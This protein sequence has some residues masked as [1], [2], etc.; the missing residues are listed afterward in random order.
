VI[1]KREV[2][3]IFPV[4]PAYLGCSV[5]VAVVVSA[6]GRALQASQA[7]NA[8]ATRRRQ[9]GLVSSNPP[10]LADRLATLP[11]FEY[12]L[13][14]DYQVLIERLARVGARCG[15]TVSV[16]YAQ[17]WRGNFQRVTSCGIRWVPPLPTSCE[18]AVPQTFDRSGPLDYETTA[19]LDALGVDR[20]V[21]VPVGEDGCPFAIL[22]VG[23]RPGDALP[24]DSVAALSSVA[25][26]TAAALDL[27]RRHRALLLAAPAFAEQ[28]AAAIAWAGG[29]R[30]ERVLERVAAS[31]R[32]VAGAQSCHVEL[33]RESDQSLETIAADTDG[34]WHAQPA[35]GA[36]ST[37]AERQSVIRALEQ[38]A[39]VEWVEGD[40]AAPDDLRR[41]AR[42]QGARAALVVPLYWQD[43]HIGVL[44]LYASHALHVD[45][46]RLHLLEALAA[47]AALA[48]E[49]TRL[50]A[51]LQRAI[52]LDSLTGLLNHR[53][54]QQQLDRL[55]R[56]AHRTAK[57]LSL[58]MIDV[59]GF[60]RF[61]ETHGHVAGDE[62]L[63]L[64]AR[65]LERTSRAGDLIARFGGD[66]FVLVLPGTVAPDAEAVGRRIL[67]QAGELAVSAG[68][69][70][71]PVALSIGIAS[72]PA[73]GR[74]RSELLD[75]ARAATDAAREAGPGQVQRG[76]GVPAVGQ[77]ALSALAVLDG[78]VSAIDRKD[79]Y[80]RQHSDVVT[81]AAVRLASAL[82][83]SPATHDVLQIAG[84]VHDVGKIAVPDAILMK[85]GPLTADERVLMQQH[86]EYGL[87]LIRDVPYL[88]DVIDAV[89]HHH[90]RWD[91]TG[92]P[93]GR[94]GDEIPLVGRIM[95]IADAYSAMIV[96]RPYRKRRQQAEAFEE[97]RA[98]AGTQFDPDLVEPFIHAMYEAPSDRSTQPLRPL[99]RDGEERRRP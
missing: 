6:T 11:D 14:D 58:L 29:E 83:L 91:G 45:R 24:P 54:L 1:W 97:L 21:V 74:T 62:L 99:L 51:R 12:D 57:P 55:L 64:V 27:E 22:V 25:D 71:L 34:D 61:N 3:T 93:R 77:D 44:S 96:D 89:L 52:D 8:R 92:Y 4:T 78:L 19:W 18:T 86:V 60:R 82:Q 87:M 73:D 67:S 26:L 10:A 85:P 59:A 43:H 63:R 70:Q 80:T 41:R 5:E 17:H 94:S 31:A 36:Y 39:V 2:S 79:R 9:A 23:A 35:V 56:L 69:E 46:K 53:A 50:H 47:E 75:V 48:I 76:R 40:P 98:G 20:V 15:A 7:R 13:A 30:I 72:F 81:V 32:L 42:T 95:A 90:E 68:G 38:R 28:H 66:E 49:H 65:L 37:F 84:P 88:P 33:V 16:V